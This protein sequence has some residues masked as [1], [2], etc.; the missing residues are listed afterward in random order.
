MWSLAMPN[1][2]NVSFSWYYACL[3]ILVLYVPGSPVMYSH[4]MH[5]RRKTLGG[6]AADAKK[7][8]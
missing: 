4:M 3:F 1:A 8:A 2:W 6:G 5:Q 7:R